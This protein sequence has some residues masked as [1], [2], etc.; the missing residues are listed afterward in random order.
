MYMDITSYIL[1]SSIDVHFTLNLLSAVILLSIV[2]Q[3][4][5]KNFDLI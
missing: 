4:D 1:I 2:Y 5:A 3:G